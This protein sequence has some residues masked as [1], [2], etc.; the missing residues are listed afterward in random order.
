MIDVDLEIS[1]VSKQLM[2]F[3]QLVINC[4]SCSSWETTLQ[5]NT[6]TC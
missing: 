4:T 3:D 5:Q 2:K 1:L 6:M